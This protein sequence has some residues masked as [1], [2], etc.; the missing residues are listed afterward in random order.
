MYDF[1]DEDDFEQLGFEGF[2]QL[3]PTPE[4]PSPKKGPSLKARAIDFLS[5]REHSR[6]ELQRKLQRHCDDMTLI[7]Q[8]LDE[9]EAQNWLNN[10]RFVQSYVNRRAHKLGQRR[11][12]QELRQQGVET[13]HLEQVREQLQDS[14]FDRAYEVW[15]R[16]FGALPT[17]QKSYAKQHRFMA[18][19]GFS[20]DF[21]RKILDRFKDNVYQDQG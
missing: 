13:H 14:E 1:D 4:A 18:S 20:P 17:D 9:L 2:E 19:R 10:E 7:Q 15:E 16:K 5:R 6:L 21:L 8:L 3:D 11:V 12:L